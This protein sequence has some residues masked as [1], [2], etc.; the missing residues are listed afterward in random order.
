MTLHF[1]GK[2]ILVGALALSL[3]AGS[4]LAAP[5]NVHA[6][7][8]STPFTDISSGHWAEKHVAKLA[9]QGIITGYASGSTYVFKPNQSVSQQEA[10][11]MAL[12]FAGLDDQ[13]DDDAIIGFPNNF[14]V[15]NYYKPYILLAFSLGLLDQQEEYANAAKDAKVSWGT[16]P[17]SREWVT[18]LMIR[19][20]DKEDE[21]ERLKDAAS[22]F[23]DAGQID[24]KYKG[25][26]NA[27]SELEL[28]KGVTAEKFDPK[29]NVTRA[30]LATLFSR[31]QKLYP[32]EYVGQTDG[33]L[34]KLTDTAVTLYSE[35]KE[36][37][38]TVDADTLYYHYDSEKA[39]TKQQL[40]EYGDASVIAKDGKA[41]YVEVKGETQHVKSTSG[42]LDR[43]I[44]GENKIYVWINNEPIP[45]Y[46][47]D[48]T[49]IVDSEGKPLSLGDLQRDTPISIVQ[50]T[51]RDNPATIKIVAAPAST[52][53]MAKG[54]FYGTVGDTIT[55]MEGT[56]L[57]SK[58][59]A[60][61]VTVEIDGMAG[62][63]T[64][65]LLKEA[66][67][68]ELS[69]NATGEVTKIKVTNRNVKVLAGAQIAAF[70]YDKKLLTIVD[71][72]GL[73]AQALYFT[74]KTRIDYNGSSITLAS[75]SSMLTQNRKV[76]VSYTGNTIVSLQFVTG[77]TGTLTSINGSTSQ[78]TVKLDSGAEVTLPYQNAGIEINGITSA[79]LTDLKIG[80]TLT[81]GLT[82]TQDRIA[83]I[84]VHSLT[85]YEVV[86]VDAINKKLRI[87][88]ATTPLFELSVLSTQLLNEAG[89][90]LT[91]NQIAPG[92]IVNATYVGKQ[93][94]VVRVV[95]VTQGKVT[96]VTGSG[97][98]IADMTGKSV[99]YGEGA[100][101]IVYKGTAQG[102]STSLLTVGDY[103][104]VVKT[105]N[106]KTQFTAAVAES[107]IFT[108]FNAADSQ[109][110]TE[111]TTSSDNRNYFN[112]TNSTKYTQNGSAI[113]LQS[114]KSGDV[115]LI[116]GFR[117]N[118]LEIVKQ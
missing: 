23:A 53:T 86:S 29:A 68:V 16:K 3:V 73:N 2:K 6:A 63:T 89:A 52:P 57:V 91:V 38:Y 79:S 40:I 46:Y 65:D 87:K 80:D 39:I 47:T 88:N 116:Y 85:Q 61:S 12:R 35:G 70:L 51:F 101:F 42:T 17:A 75:A 110:W 71:A 44:A 60:D 56:S 105:E 62:A 11:L 98:A 64:A 112:V 54:T 99:T 81:L 15:N 118:A 106:G 18:K 113:T 1:A 92:A 55:I 95:N 20:I 74:D 45:F 108:S 83:S 4:G 69:L 93:T 26:V 97:V 104:E 28:V 14:T 24:G 50:D 21:A 13:V 5:V 100:G 82:S 67:Q 102:T 117:N 90:T 96:S 22:S 19:A 107:R 114:L 58:F 36:T 37:T 66:D 84:K 9:L 77:Y 43:V 94:T 34:T 49:A 7:A 48:S 59:L 41:L 31:A 103:V 27:A 25:Y 30:S 10:V 111:K 78:L 115:I 33:I 109:I 72:S 76:V 8:L 32:V